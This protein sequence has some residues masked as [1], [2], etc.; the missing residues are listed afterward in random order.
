V[1]EPPR[2]RRP[3]DH[4]LRVG[5]LLILGLV[6]FVI[7]RALLVP[8]DFGVYGF[9]R[10][11]ALDDARAQP[12][13]FGGQSSCVTCHAPVVK[14]RTGTRHAGVHCEACHGPL[15]QH[16]SDR[17]VKPAALDPVKLCLQ[18]H[19]KLAGKPAFM[20]QIVPAD[21]SGDAECTACHKPHSP[22]IGG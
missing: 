9:Y 16:V 20:P 5:G 8:A 21:H 18:C 6:L 17:A 3:Y 1:P 11:G 14:E 7:V 10:A 4:V 2:Q 13:V 15:A 19:R 12:V 22:K